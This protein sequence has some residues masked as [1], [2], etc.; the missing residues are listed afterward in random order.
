LR[1]EDHPEVT[2]VAGDQRETLAALKASPGKDSWLFGVGR[3]SVV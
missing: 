3:C 2:I 1:Q